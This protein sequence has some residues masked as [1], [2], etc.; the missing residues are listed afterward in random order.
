MRHEARPLRGGEEA[1]ASV[2]I[3]PW[4]PAGAEVL[5]RPASGRIPP[6]DG[7][8][9]TRARCPAVVR[10][11]RIVQLLRRSGYVQAADLTRMLGVSEMTIRRDLDELV[12][13]GLGVRVWGGLVTPGLADP[14]S[15]IGPDEMDDRLDPAHHHLV[16]AE[17]ALDAGR[18]ADAR[19]HVRAILRQLDRELA[20][21]AGAAGAG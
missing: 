10:R 11:R 16:L 5:S 18:L 4:D 9:G 13:A 14:G 7:A 1:A 2:Q 6:Q 15:A 12:R 8:A 3:G 21:D 19:V 20:V 17:Q